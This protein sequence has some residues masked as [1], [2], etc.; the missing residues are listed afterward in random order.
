MNVKMIERKREKIKEKGKK[1]RINAKKAEEY[2]EN[3]RRE[4]D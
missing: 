2:S 4:E 1:Q 3:E